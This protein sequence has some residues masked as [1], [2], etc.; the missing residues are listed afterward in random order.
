MFFVN[1]KAALRAA[2]QDV[3]QVRMSDLSHGKIRHLD[4]GLWNHE[5]AGSQRTQLGAQLGHDECSL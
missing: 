4:P 2:L 1:G 3:G 5:A